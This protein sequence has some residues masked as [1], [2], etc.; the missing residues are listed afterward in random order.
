[1]PLPILVFFIGRRDKPQRMDEGL[2][3]L[4]EGLD[5]RRLVQVIAVNYYRDSTTVQAVPTL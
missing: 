4:L 1:L 2:M 5:L 3:A